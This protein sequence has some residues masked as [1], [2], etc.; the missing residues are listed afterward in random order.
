MGYTTAREDMVNRT[1]LRGATES[2]GLVVGFGEGG[3]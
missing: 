3:G 1:D 2:G